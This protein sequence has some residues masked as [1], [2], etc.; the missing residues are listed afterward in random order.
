MAFYCFSNF[1]SL[2]LVFLFFSNFLSLFLNFPLF[3]RFFFNK[4]VIFDERDENITE[5]YSFLET[6]RLKAEG[7]LV[8]SLKGLSRSCCVLAG[9]FMKK[10]KWTLYKTLEFLHS[11]RPDLEIRASFFS[12]MNRLEAKLSLKGNIQYNSWENLN[13]ISAIREEEVIIRNTY[14]NSRQIKPS[15]EEFMGLNPKKFT[16]NSIEKKRNLYWID[17]FFRDKTKLSTEIRPK[18]MNSS[19][20]LSKK[21]K[22]TV[23]KSILKGSA[24][25]SSYNHKNLLRINDKINEQNDKINNK[26]INNFNENQSVNN[27]PKFTRP[28]TPNPE[29]ESFSLKT[30]NYKEI[31]NFSKK[32]SRPSTPTPE[33]ENLTSKTLN[34]L[35]EIENS[36]S[37]INQLINKNPLLLRKKVN[38]FLEDHTNTEKIENN[39]E[40]GLRSSSLPKNNEGILKG[41]IQR[42]NMLKKDIGEILNRSEQISREDEEKKVGK[43]EN[44]MNYQRLLFESGSLIKKQVVLLERL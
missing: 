8:H 9:Y 19:Y 37:L 39:A 25:D 36:K 17:E 27:R 5:I 28:S 6:A 4:Q 40:N 23:L 10:F 31:E 11:R 1:L 2:F 14:L 32:L 12:Q 7:C 26:F 22:K 33:H 34:N 21:P 35:K 43:G 18:L 30:K 24:S 16:R 13:E 42:R 29:H 41:N 15:F 38:N 44:E 3:Y 20:I